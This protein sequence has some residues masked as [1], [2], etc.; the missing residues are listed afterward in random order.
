[1]MQGRVGFTSNVGDGS[2]F[3]VEIPVHRHVTAEIT[4]SSAAQ[5]AEIGLE[6]IHAHR[7]DAVILDINLPGMSGFDAM[8]RLRESPETRHIPV[9]GCRQG[10]S[11]EIQHARTSSASTSTSPSR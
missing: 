7:P 4:A 1:M 9:I 3:W 5:T 10:H 11:S 2:E 8:Q 6:W